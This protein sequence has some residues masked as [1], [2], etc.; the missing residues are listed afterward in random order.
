MIM[1]FSCHLR[2]LWNLGLSSFWTTLLI[3]TC[4]GVATQASNKIIQG[5]NQILFKNCHSCKMEVSLPFIQAVFA[6]SVYPAFWILSKS[7]SH[8]GGQCL[9]HNSLACTQLSPCLCHCR[10]L[11]VLKTTAAPIPKCHLMVLGHEHYRKKIVYILKG[12]YSTALENAEAIKD[13]EYVASTR[14]LLQVMI[15]M[16]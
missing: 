3:L 4:S 8:R 13:I 12:V 2:S 7:K 15:W 11:T 10:Q 1:I 16:G 5:V 14:S 6:V 9:L